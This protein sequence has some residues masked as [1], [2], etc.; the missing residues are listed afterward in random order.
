MGRRLSSTHWGGQQKCRNGKY[1]A[2]GERLKAAIHERTSIRQV[3]RI[4]L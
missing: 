3:E 1:A 4:C 2:S